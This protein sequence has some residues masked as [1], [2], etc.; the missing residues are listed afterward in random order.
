MPLAKSLG[1]SKCTNGPLGVPRIEWLA[2][3]FDSSGE[4]RTR[5]VA[6]EFKSFAL[7]RWP[8]RPYP[9]RSIAHQSTYMASPGKPR[10]WQRRALTSVASRE[11]TDLLAN[12]PLQPSAEMASPWSQSSALPHANLFDVH[13]V[14]L[15]GELD[16]VS[17][18]GLTVAPVGIAASTAMRRLPMDFSMCPS[19]RSRSGVA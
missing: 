4:T 11:L 19:R 18:R 10:A 1:V 9:S 5:L 2:G 6:Q 3:A 16:I 7:R 14:V 15:R 12:L 17:A 8:C 13:V